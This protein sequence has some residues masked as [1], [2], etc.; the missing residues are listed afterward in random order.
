MVALEDKPEAYLVPTLLDFKGALKVGFSRADGC[1]MTDDELKDMI[2]GTVVWH[3]EIFSDGDG[4][5]D[6]HGVTHYP[7]P[8]YRAK[9]PN[10]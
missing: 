5:T 2:G 9:V 4:V 10:V 6:K 8:L 3:A 7:V 1:T